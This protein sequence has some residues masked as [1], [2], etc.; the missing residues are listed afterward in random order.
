ME[1]VEKWD[2]VKE[3]MK[4]IMAYLDRDDITEISVNRFDV[5]YIKHRDGTTEKLDTHFKDESTVATI[6][7]Q[8]GIA[9]NVNVNT[10]E[11]P[12]V[13]ARLWNGGR[14]AG[15][16]YPWS[17]RGSSFSIR[18]VPK[19]PITINDIL[20]YR[21][22]TKEMV[23]FMSMAIKLRRNIMVSGSTDSGK[24]SLLNALSVYI[25]PTD[26]VI[27]IE[28]TSE[29][30]LKLD[31]YIS[32]IA[33]NKKNKDG[34]LIK[35]LSDLIRLSLRENP[36]R[37]FVGEIRDVDSAVSFIRAL[38]TGHNGCM[39]TTHANSPEDTIDRLTDLLAEGGSSHEFARSLIFSNLHI[40]VQAV[41][42]KG[43]G[44][45]VVKISEINPNGTIKDI[46]DYDYLDDKHVFIHENYED[47]FLVNEAS[48]FIVI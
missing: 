22:M 37:V 13:N 33:V 25:D 46:F 17:A 21:S 32:H 16:L 6:I 41:S 47:S 14:F 3:Y 30:V 44:K 1:A 19:K 15:S 28:D 27:S 34:K 31:N 38:N 8:V 40:I 23:D 48:K 5:I 9:I 35:S 10:M 29:I 39:S 26:R 20:D 18:I 42:I 36:D 7:T 43:V 12:E 2:L 4:P 45:R 24:T 11:E